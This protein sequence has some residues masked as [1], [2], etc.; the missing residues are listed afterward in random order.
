MTTLGTDLRRAVR[1]QVLVPGDDGFEAARLPWNRAV[2]QRVAAVVE[3]EDAADAAAAVRCARLAGLAVAVQPSGHGATTHLDG[4]IL[5]RTGRLRGM[6]VLP[7][8]RT[9]RVEA[10]VRWGELLTATGKHG[11]TGLPGSS[12][13]VSVTGY[14]LGGGLGWFARRHGWAAGGVRAFE[15]VGADGSQARVTAGSD[16][17]LFWALRGGGGDFALVTA[18]EIDLHPAPLLYGGRMLWP[19]DRAPEVLAAYREV[20]AAAPVELTAWFAMV[21]FPPAP[22]V[23]EPLRGLAAVAVDSTFLG[24]EEEG[25]D[26]LRRFEDIPGL[27]RD[28]RAAMPLDALGGI[29]AEPTQ[30]VPGAGRAELLTGLGDAVADDLLAAA[31]DVAP[32]GT[33]Q[34]RHLGGAL[35]RPADGGGACGHVAEPYLLSMVGPVMSPE[36]GQAVTARLAQIAGALAPHT[37]GRKPFTYLNGDEKAA[38]AFDAETLARLREIKRR[39]DP[40]G[41]FR[42]GRPVLA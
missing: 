38:S 21:K 5:L 30:P 4:T 24:G 3:V 12:P 11:L 27:L 33:V 32:L 42:A 1:G 39:R 23:P 31:G 17:D 2:D 8:R 40:D 16:P 15:V 13:V 26:L 6:E 20:T 19:A 37:T 14:T 28:S 41:V 9:A 10:G 18:M 22:Q 25:C 29:C 35:S 7:E 36:G 34:V